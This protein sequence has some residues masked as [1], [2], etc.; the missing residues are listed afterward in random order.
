MFVSSVCPQLPSS[1]LFCNENAQTLCWWIL[2]RGQRMQCES[3]TTFSIARWRRSS[4]R[5]L[6]MDP[7]QKSRM[8]RRCVYINMLKTTSRNSPG[9]QRHTWLIWLRLDWF[10]PCRDPN[11][12]AVVYM[13]V[14]LFPL[15]FSVLF[16]LLWVCLSLA[17]SLSALS[18]IS[19]GAGAWRRSN[20]NSKQCWQ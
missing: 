10:P 18:S 7:L 16:F 6:T 3:W 13:R 20:R 15:C 1:M 19:P 11:K 4:F 9:T 12:C 8:E 17:S 5:K 2:Y 14:C